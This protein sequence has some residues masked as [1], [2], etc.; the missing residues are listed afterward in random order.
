MQENEKHDLFLFSH[1][2]DV[3]VFYSMKDKSRN[4]TDENKY[5]HN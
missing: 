5:K 2:W 1:P 4:D 3:L